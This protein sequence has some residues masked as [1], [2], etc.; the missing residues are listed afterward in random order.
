MQNCCID[1][2]L[3]VIY[4]KLLCLSHR[5][6]ELFRRSF[7]E[8]IQKKHC[9]YSVFW[10]RSPRI[11]CFW[12]S[13]LANSAKIYTRPRAGQ[14]DTMCQRSD[15]A[16]GYFSDTITWSYLWFRD[17]TL[18]QELLPNIVHI[19]FFC[20]H[21]RQIIQVF[22]QSK[23]SICRDRTRLV[24]RDEEKL[25][26]TMTDVQKELFP[27]IRTVYGNIKSW[28]SVCCFKTAFA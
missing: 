20:R 28:Q 18:F 6:P 27:G 7:S 5:I 8:S 2:F 12:I 14:Q 1:H 19:D 23:L 22:W 25:L 10:T 17:F 9:K 13:P 11:C 24:S 15:R 3:F 26:S 21:G 4:A 16:Q